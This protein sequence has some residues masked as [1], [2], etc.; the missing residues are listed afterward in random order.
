MHILFLK[1]SCSMHRA[2]LNNYYPSLDLARGLAMILVIMGHGMFPVH[3]ALDSFH[4]PL[5]F[6]IAGFTFRPSSDWPVFL[7]KKTNRVFIPFIFFSFISF[8]VEFFAQKEA[9]FI[10]PLWF[11]Q[12]LFIALILINMVFNSLDRIKGWIILVISIVSYYLAYYCVDCFPFHILKA[13]NALPFIYLG[14]LI[15]DLILGLTRSKTL[16]LL[17]LFA[18]LY[19]LM[20]VLSM[21]C[22]HISGLWHTFGIF[23]SNIFFYYLTAISGSIVVLCLAQFFKVIGPINW[24]GRNSLVIM[25]AHFPILEALNS[26]IAQTEWYLTG[27]IIVKASLAMATFFLV[28]ALCYPLVWICKNYLPCVTGYK[29]LIVY[30]A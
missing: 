22:Y 10:G 21:R 12:T 28:I 16:V 18:V 27:G 25:C 13:I 20:F 5:F 14:F 17:L 19:A 8:G 1:K 11:L 2:I 26:F 3:Q 9:P 24:I 15:K 30:G 23:R 29:P 7:I 6:I 4:M